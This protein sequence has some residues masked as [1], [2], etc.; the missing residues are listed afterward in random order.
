MKTLRFFTAI[1]FSILSFTA[2]SQDFEV[3]PVLMSFNADPGEIQK[4]ALSIINHTGRPQK[5]ILKLSDYTVDREGNKKNVAI[6]ANKHSCID[7]ITISPSLIEL[8]PNQTANVDIIMTVPKDGF[9]TRWCMIGVQAVEEH[10]AAEVD[11]TLSSGVL[12]VPRIVVLVKQSPKSN[13]NYK[14][15]I[16]NL[17]EVTKAGEKFRTFEVLITNTGDNI[18][19]A[20]VSLALA[21]MQSAKEEK[22]PAEKVTVYP[23]ASRVVRLKIP[24]DI[25]KGKYALA[26]ILDYGHRQ[27]LE[28]TQMMLEVK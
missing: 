27:P 17:K 7:W 4:Q 2:F 1:L 20:S 3:S 25:A 9:S 28:G 15:N 21:D 12:I 18:I 8:N 26:A 24:K 10:S 19:D 22:F 16:S 14:A 11:K 6:G 13:R 5:Y 23:E